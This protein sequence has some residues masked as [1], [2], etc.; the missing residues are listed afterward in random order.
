MAPLAKP[1]SQSKQA[2][3]KLPR[4]RCPRN[5]QT[6][7]RRP[8]TS[9]HG[10]ASPPRKLIPRKMTHLS[11]LL[12]TRSSFGASTTTM[13]QVCG[14]STI[15]RIVKAARVPAA[16]LPMPTSLHSTPWTVTLTRNDCCARVKSLLGS[17][18]QSCATSSGCCSQMMWEC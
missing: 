15:Q 17:G 7:R 2:R 6:K 8:L 1:A 9:G 16:H 13:V 10:R 4:K 12:K 3:N 14:P 18:L 11:K 5:R